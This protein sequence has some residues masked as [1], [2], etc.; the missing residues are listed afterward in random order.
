MLCWVVNIL[1]IITVV[2]KKELVLY[3]LTQL[4]STYLSLWQLFN[5]MKTNCIWELKFQ[6]FMLAHSMLANSLFSEYIH[7]MCKICARKQFE[8][9]KVRI[10]I[11][12]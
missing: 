3:V 2:L 8:W 5:S 1:N 11:I 12:I 4:V 7:V 9:K 10:E 6:H